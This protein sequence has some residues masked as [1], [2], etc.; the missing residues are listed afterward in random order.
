MLINVVTMGMMK[1]PIMEIV[2]VVTMLNGC[3]AAIWAVNVV[4]IWMFVAILAHRS[5]LIYCS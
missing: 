4:V 2:D 3:M 5:L 1:V